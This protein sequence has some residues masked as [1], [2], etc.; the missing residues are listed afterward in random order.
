MDND[1]RTGSDYQPAKS[2]VFPHIGL[3]YCFRCIHC[4]PLRN[5][6]CICIFML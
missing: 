6:D 3:V 4:Y 1:I 5:K 2:I